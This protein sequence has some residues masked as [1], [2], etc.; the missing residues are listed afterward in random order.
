[1][2]LVLWLQELGVWQV[3]VWVW[4]LEVLEVLVQVRDPHE[5]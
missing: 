3:E 4:E 1:M 5:L 2:A